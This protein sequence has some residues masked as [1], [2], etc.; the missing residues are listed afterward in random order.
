MVSWYKI[1]LPLNPLD[2]KNV[3]FHHHFSRLYREGN[4][5][6]RGRMVYFAS[7][8]PNPISI[9]YFFAPECYAGLKAF[10]DRFN[11][12]RCEKPIVTTLQRYQPTY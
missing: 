1:V 12:E 5:Y 9:T 7:G 8:T 10:I 3:G 4:E 11:P 6:L 2:P